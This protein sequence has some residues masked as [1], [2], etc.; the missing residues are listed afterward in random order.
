M[1]RQRPPVI[2]RCAIRNSTCRSTRINGNAEGMFVR[3]E[4]HVENT[5]PGGKDN[6]SFGVCRFSKR[7]STRSVSLSQGSQRLVPQYASRHRLPFLRPPR[8]VHGLRNL[9]DFIFSRRT[10]AVANAG[11]RDSSP[12]HISRRVRSCGNFHI[13]EYGARSWLTPSESSASFRARDLFRLRFSLTPT[14]PSTTVFAPPR[15]LSCRVNTLHGLLSPP[16]SLSLILPVRI[17]APILVRRRNV[18]SDGP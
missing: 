17:R 6:R 13:L 10:T 7:D 14:V 1:K 15:V 9:A 3:I 18:E 12:T 4:C 5:S 2:D 16:F 8:A 11:L